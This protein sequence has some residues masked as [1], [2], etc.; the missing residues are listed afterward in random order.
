MTVGSPGGTTI[1]SSIF[2]VIYYRLVMGMELKA[3]VEEPRIYS[4]E[5]PL[6]RWEKGVPDEVRMELERRGHQFEAFPRE[7]GNAN[8]MWINSD[9]N[10]FH[11]VGDSS[12]ESTAIGLRFVD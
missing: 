11:G 7:I 2:Q 3:A 5:Y 12:R 9:T 8:C 10:E 1:L 4:I 6:I